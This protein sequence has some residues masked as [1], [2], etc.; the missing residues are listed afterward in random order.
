[1]RSNQTGSGVIDDPGAETPRLSGSLEREKRLRDAP[2]WCRGVYRRAW[3]GRSRKAAIRAFCLECVGW[4]PSE[5]RRCTAPACPLF[6]F[7]LK[8]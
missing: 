3:Q 8:G 4:S 5:V 6:E 1:M 2:A 7:R